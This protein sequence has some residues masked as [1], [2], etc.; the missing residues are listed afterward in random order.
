MTPANW[1][2]LQARAF[3]YKTRPP[4]LD[5]V[6]GRRLEQSGAVE[7]QRTGPVRAA[8]RLKTSPGRLGHRHAQA[9]AGG[10]DWRHWRVNEHLTI[11]FG[12]RWDA[13]WGATRR[14]TCPK[15]RS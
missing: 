1:N 7:S 5:A 6:P 15:R 12:V 8:L 10:V 2:V 13:D 9:D 3:V 14:R 11:N 4:D